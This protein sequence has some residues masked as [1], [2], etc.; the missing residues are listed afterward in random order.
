MTNYNTWQLTERCV[1][2]CYLHDQG[3]FNTLV[4]YDDCSKT[5]FSG[6]FPDTTRLYKGATN[7]GLTKALNVAFSKIDEDIII[8]FDSDAYPTTSFCDEVR[9]IFENDP[10]IGLI[11]FHTIGKSGKP[12]ESYTTEPNVW[13]LLLGQALYA[14]TEK[15]L[16]DRSGRI[17]VFTC[18]MAM[19]NSAFREVAGFDENFDW[20]DLDHDFSMKINRSNWKIAI[21]PNARVFHEGGGTPQLT[22]NR[23]LRF[24][25]TRWYLLRKFRRIPMKT[26]VKALIV[27]RLYSEYLVLLVLGPILIRDKMVRSDKLQGRRELIN[28]CIANY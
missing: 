11:A 9:E 1:Q 8:L 22:R 25:K 21:A 5:E 4:V 3:N 27:L 7:L 2:H 16:A 10:S 13:G 19:R 23:V 6:T 12:T 28:Y 26:L 15:W 20:L 17:S 18:A 14:K 24:Y